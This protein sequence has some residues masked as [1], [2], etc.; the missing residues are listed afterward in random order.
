MSRL[1]RFGA[2]LVCAPF[3]VHCRAQ[4]EPPATFIFESVAS[5]SLIDARPTGKQKMAVFPRTKSAWFT[6][7]T[8]GRWT[9][10]H[11]QRSSRNVSTGNP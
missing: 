9:R 2:A 7:V 6:C 1:S 4:L 3:T 11:P 5:H 10:Q 8:S